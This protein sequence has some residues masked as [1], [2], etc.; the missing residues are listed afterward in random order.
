[1]RMLGTAAGLGFAMTLIAAAANA[2]NIVDMKGT[3]I[4]QAEAIVDGPA[5]HHPA[6]GAAGTAPAGKYRLSEPTF[7]LVIEGQSGR[8]FW[9]TTS[10]ATHTER[11]LGSLSFDGKRI[12][13]VDDDGYNDG[14][15]IDADTFESC[16]RHITA[17]SAVVACAIAKRKK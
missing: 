16:Y 7:T 15:M 12:H 1:M 6:P 17:T 4:G 11:L 10:S 9:G 2:Q 5:Q 13:M 14:V 3:W 8:R